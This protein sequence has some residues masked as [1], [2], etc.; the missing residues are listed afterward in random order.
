MISNE[1]G[2]N[3]RQ[4]KHELRGTV[5]KQEQL[6]S[7]ILGNLDKEHAEDEAADLDLTSEE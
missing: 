3:I 7:T 4:E 2:E 1:E 6:I 5:K